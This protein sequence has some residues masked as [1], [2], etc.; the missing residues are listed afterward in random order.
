MVYL[1]VVEIRNGI[2]KRVEVAEAWL[3]SS[4]QG[5]LQLQTFILA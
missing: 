2:S 5:K 4:I 3:G 1:M